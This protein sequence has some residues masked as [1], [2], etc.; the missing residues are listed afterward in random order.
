MILTSLIQVYERDLNK[1]KNE[2]ESYTD[3]A[4][5]WKLSGEINNTG[6]NLCLHI[7]GNLNHYIGATLGE[8]G[9]Q[10]DRDSEFAR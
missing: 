1:L 9:Y 7:V 8:T 4:D 6:G 10:R 5:L 3:E 2:I